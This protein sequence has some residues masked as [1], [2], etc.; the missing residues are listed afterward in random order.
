MKLK[1][2][3]TRKGCEDGFTVKEYKQGMIYDIRPSLA[4][5]F[6]AAGFAIRLDEYSRPRSRRLKRHPPNFAKQNYRGIS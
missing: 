2:L 3:M 5:A 6:L 4:R 1:M